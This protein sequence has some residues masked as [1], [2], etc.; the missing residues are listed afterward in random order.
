MNQYIKLFEPWSLGKLTVPNRIALAPMGA[1]LGTEDGFI[2]D[3]EVRFYEERAAG[4]AGLIV[5][6]NSCV[7]W[8]R[9]KANTAQ[10][11]TDIS[12]AVTGLRALSERVQYYG[13]LVAAQL[14]HAGGQT[15]LERT[16]NMHPYAAS[17]ISMKEGLVPQEMTK[18]DIKHVIGCF[19]QST[20]TTKRAGFNC[21]EIHGA[22]GYLVSQFLSPL[23][24][25]RK[26]EYGGDVKNR[27]RFAVELVDEIRK[28]AGKAFPII[29]RINGSDR[30]QNGVTLEECQYIAR[31]LEE[32]GVSAISISS[33]LNSLSRDWVFPTELHGTGTNVEFAYN[34]KKAVSIPVGVA[35][36]IVSPDHA[37]EILR[38]GKADFVVMGRPL[39]ADPQW[40]KKAFLGK[41]DRIRPCLYC[42]NGCTKHHHNNWRIGCDVNIEAGREI[43]WQITPAAKQHLNILV[44]GGGPAGMEAAC[45]AVLRGHNV[46]L[47]EREDVL[48]GQLNIAGIPQ[49]KQRLM[50][51][52]R[53]MNGEIKRLGVEVYVSTE[54]N[55]ETIKNYKFNGI[56]LAVGAQCKTPV[57]LSLQN[58]SVK[59]I[60]AWTAFKKGVGDARNVTIIGGGHVGVDLALHIRTFKNAPK[61]RIV[62]MLPELLPESDPGTKMCLIRNLKERDVTLMP[63]CIVETTQ[64]ENTVSIKDLA[65]GKEQEYETD[66]VIVAIGANCCT[67]TGISMDQ[68][69]LPVIRVGDA[70]RPRGIWEATHEGAFSILQIEKWN[71]F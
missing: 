34:V 22:H 61:V 66:L 18:E 24:N 6:E 11:R 52:M 54:I 44:A 16:E 50:E 23:L 31:A 57:N 56:V 36:R 45:R 2:S 33:G 59:A 25:Q 63:Q 15:T 41:Q 68:L 71:N 4:G 32:A 5:I 9:G 19:A 13:S 51:Y 35:G 58:C 40:G 29:F 70:I 7:E 14:Q 28:T 17:P 43:D 30:Y 65:T 64:K 53:Y 46:K 12:K 26:D 21:V 38:E 20:F 1:L 10:T 60:D 8:P 62:E 37:E 49:H 67:T 42:N 3:R 48:G 69:R 55:A 27:V 39:I 47:F